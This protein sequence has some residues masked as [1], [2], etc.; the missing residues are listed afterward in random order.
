MQNRNPIKIKSVGAAFLQAA[1]QKPCRVFF[2][3]LVIFAAATA[4][5]FLNFPKVGSFSGAPKS[6]VKNIFSGAKVKEYDKAFD[7]IKQRQE[8]YRQPAGSDY[9]DVFSLSA[10]DPDSTT[11]ESAELTNPEN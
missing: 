11:T 5:I 7:S 4:I 9:Q 3:L 2:C 8:N 6:A 10:P 1:A